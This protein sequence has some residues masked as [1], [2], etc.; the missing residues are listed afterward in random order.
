M[1]PSVYI[2]RAKARKDA[3]GQKVRRSR[4]YFAHLPEAATFMRDLN[5]GCGCLAQIVTPPE[6]VLRERY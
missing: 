1:I 4:C 2:P 6:S 3:K 5:P